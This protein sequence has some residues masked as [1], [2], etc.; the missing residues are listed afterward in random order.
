MLRKPKEPTLDPKLFQL[1]RRYM[2]VKI[3]KRVTTD[4]GAS[5]LV[6]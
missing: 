2:L 4:G 6:V 5:I 3:R 1:G